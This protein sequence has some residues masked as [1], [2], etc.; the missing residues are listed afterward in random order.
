V[1]CHSLFRFVKNLLS[2]PETYRI[3]SDIKVNTLAITCSLEHLTATL[4][5]IL[6]NTEAGRQTLSGMAP[7][8]R[9]LWIYH[10]IEETEHKAVAFDVFKAVGGGYVRRAWQHLL[11]TAIFLVVTFGIYFKF[12]WDAGHLFNIFSHANLLYFLFVSPGFFRV[13]LPIWCKYF[14]PSFHPWGKGEAGFTHKW[15]RIIQTGKM[16]SLEELHNI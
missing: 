11:S 6:L 4:A 9:A 5:E 15:D 3:F 10:A 16:V 1:F 7:S 2:I 8:H 12:M 13:A 14:N